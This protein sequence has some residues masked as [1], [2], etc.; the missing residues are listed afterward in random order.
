M[1]LTTRSRRP[2]SNPACAHDL[3]G[4]RVLVQGPQTSLDCGGGGDRTVRWSA[5]RGRG[6]IAME[7]SETRCALSWS[8]RTSLRW[9]VGAGSGDCLFMY[10][11][12]GERGDGRG[13]LPRGGDKAAAR[14]RSG[15]PV[16]GYRLGLLPEGNREPQK[17][18]EQER[19][20][21]STCVWGHTLCL[22][23]SGARGWYWPSSLSKNP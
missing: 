8:C 20:G 21:V 5:A 18:C 14:P 2:F 23:I 22:R 13:K 17:A 3:F 10:V 9:E 12:A 7:G 4:Y 1:K 11:V 6:W 15:S 16:R 19:A